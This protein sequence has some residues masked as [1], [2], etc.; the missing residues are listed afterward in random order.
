MLFKQNIM[1]A[2]LACSLRVNT[3]HVRDRRHEV[4]APASLFINSKKSL[5]TSELRLNL[6]QSNDTLFIS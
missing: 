2:P 3:G 5:T 1:F 6:F 4:T